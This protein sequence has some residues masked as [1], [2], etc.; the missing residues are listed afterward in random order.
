MICDTLTKTIQYTAAIVTIG[1]LLISV[2]SF[3]S[4]VYGSE[5]E[6]E[7]QMNVISFT[8]IGDVLSIQVTPITGTDYVR[9]DMQTTLSNSACTLPQ[10]MIEI[11]EDD[12]KIEYNTNDYDCK[13]MGDGGVVSLKF[14][15]NGENSFKKKKD[16]TECIFGECRR[17]QQT[18]IGGTYDISG[19]LFEVSFEDGKGFA[20]V[21]DIK[22]KTW[23]QDIDDDD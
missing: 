16:N 3:H 2:M 5:N 19:T 12:F 22:I 13:V 9:V 7:S 23:T 10:K 8:P 4:E 14:E 1:I 11:E 18:L 17:V 15:A 20:Q 6:K 21:K